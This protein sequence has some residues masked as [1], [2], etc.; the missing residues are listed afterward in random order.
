MKRWTWY[1]ALGLLVLLCSTSK[2]EHIEP[3]RF[4]ASTDIPVT[5]APT[6][7]PIESFSRGSVVDLL[8]QSPSPSVADPAQIDFFAPQ[9]HDFAADWSG[10]QRIAFDANFEP[11]IRAYDNFPIVDQAR[12][13]MSFAMLGISGILM[14]R[15]RPTRSEIVDLG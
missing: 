8:G 13:G 14:S 9:L 10:P 12:S 6:S 1:S 3:D 2:A 15:W 5:T 4:L 11:V 7:L